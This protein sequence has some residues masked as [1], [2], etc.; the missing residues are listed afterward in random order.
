MRT[1]FLHSTAETQGCKFL[2]YNQDVRCMIPSE[3]GTESQA[4]TL[5]TLPAEAPET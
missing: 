4:S 3:Q 5:P 2:Q 1:A